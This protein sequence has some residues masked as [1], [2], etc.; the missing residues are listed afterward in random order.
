MA[1]VSISEAARL[2]GKSRAT[3]HSY[4]KQGKLSKSKDHNNQQK[5]DTSE[6]IRVFGELN[7]TVKDNKVN[8]KAEH[9]N[10]GVFSKDFQVLVNEN[11][12]LKKELELTKILLD[13][14]EKRND[15]LKHTLLLIEAKLQSTT[16]NTQKKL[17]KFWK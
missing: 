15:D 5:L 16:I 13:E 14:K 7:N 2:T 10:T 8:S 11:N 3:L 4:I 9:N 12:L 6:L 1:L 17:W